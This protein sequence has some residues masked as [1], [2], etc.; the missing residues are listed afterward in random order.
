MAY[1]FQ[2]GTSRLSG[3]ATFKGDIESQGN[4]KG[5]DIS[6]SSALKVD[7]SAATIQTD[8][9]TFSLGDGNKVD[10][11]DSTNS[12]VTAELN[13]GSEYPRVY[14]FASG[15][16]NNII[17]LENNS[18]NDYMLQILNN[19]NNVGWNFNKEDSGDVGHISGSGNL[20]VKGNVT[21]AGDAEV[22]GSL[23]VD[24]DTVALNSTVEFEDGILQVSGNAGDEPSSRLTGYIF[25]RADHANGG[26]IIYNSGSLVNAE[27]HIA[28]LYGD[29]TKAP[30]KVN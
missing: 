11:R 26:L 5:V 2:L 21:I 4:L 23:T 13:G 25:G 27:K 20:E 30:V 1:K 29:G 17:K 18:S 10:L 12:K 3:S 7:G 6:G 16:V 9:G 15:N 8:L 22:N 14:F 24:G 19:A 28:I